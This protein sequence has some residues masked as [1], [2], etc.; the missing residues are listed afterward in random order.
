[1]TEREIFYLTISL[2]TFLNTNEKKILCKNFSQCD[3]L[4]RFNIKDLSILL[5]RSIR[6]KEKLGEALKVKLDRSLKIIE[7][8]HIHFSSCFDT[9]FPRA[10]KKIPEAPFAIFSRGTKLTN[11]KKIAIVGTRSPSGKGKQLAFDVARE[12]T[13]KGY[14]VTSGMA[15]GI[16]SFAHK[17][18]ISINAA[19]IAVL[20]CSVENLYPR[21]NIPLAR[22]IV[23]AGGSIVSEYPP[24]TE[25]LKFRFLERNRIVSGLSEGTVVIEA[26]Q[27]SGAL[28]TA[29]HASAQGKQV[30]VFEQMLESPQN[31]G[32]QNLQA[33]VVK[34]VDEVIDIINNKSKMHEAHGLFSYEEL[35]YE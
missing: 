32:V 26:P 3:E 20:A 6:T 5:G 31:A 21:I 27:G 14:T 17:A 9:D 12:F 4:F 1:M 11:A 28:S 33:E 34:T 8:Y 24:E 7:R 22:K 23:N 19:T 13:E 35:D 18:A 2:F 15:L 30:F 29:A 10:L 25:A 16:D